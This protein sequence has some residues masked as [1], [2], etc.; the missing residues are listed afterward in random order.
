VK[1]CPQCGHNL[2]R[3]ECPS[4]KSELESSWRHCVHCGI[5]VNA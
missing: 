2:T 1:F 4:C 3:R 5:A